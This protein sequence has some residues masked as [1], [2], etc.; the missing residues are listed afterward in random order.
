VLL[1][2]HACAPA[3]TKVPDASLSILRVLPWNGPASSGAGLP[4]V[5]G[6]ANRGGQVYFE[7]VSSPTGQFQWRIRGGNHEIMASSELY[8]DKASCQAAIAVVKREAANA[9]IHDRT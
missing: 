2:R 8:R 1:S 3:S 6:G 5:A 9:P 7:I 4:R